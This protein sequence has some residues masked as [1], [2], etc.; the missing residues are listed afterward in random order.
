MDEALDIVYIYKHKEHSPLRYSLRSLEN[1][2][3]RNVFIVGDCPA[4]LQNIIHI[5]YIFGVD[6]TQNAWGQ[7]KAACLNVMVSDRF[8]F[9]NDDFYI[10]KPTI[11][12]PYY[13]RSVDK[14]REGGAH[15]K[16]LAKTR[17]LFPNFK[18]F[19]SV[20]TP[21]IFDKRLFLS[22]YDHYDISQGYCY[23]SLYGNHYNLHT[24]VIGDVKGRSLSKVKKRMGFRFLS[25]SDNVERNVDFLS[26]INN[27]FS[28]PSKYERTECIYQP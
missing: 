27:L 20:H 23:K 26:M 28:N 16:A 14:K 6:R 21:I 13:E 11:E 15:G 19:D 18:N 12:I 7:I 5:P 24:Q 8:C 3:H 22:L 10:L 1:Y 4:Y 2:P 25:T 9:F 17:A